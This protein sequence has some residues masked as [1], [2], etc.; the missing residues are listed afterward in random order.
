MANYAV[1]FASASSQYASFAALA[2]ANPGGSNI[3]WSL[4][5]KCKGASSEDLYLLSD[6]TEY[7]IL[8][9]SGDVTYNRGG[10]VTTWVGAVTT[11]S[12]Y[13]TIRIEVTWTGGTKQAELFVNTVSKGF[14]TVGSASVGAFTQIAKHS[15]NYHNQEIDY[16]AYTDN[17]SAANNRNYLFDDGSGSTVTDSSGNGNNATLVNSPTWV[18]LS[19]GA[20]YTLTP[21]TGSLTLTGG[22]IGLLFDRVLSVGA[23]SLAASGGSIN[24]L[25]DRAIAPETGSLSLTGGAVGIYLNRVLNPETG[26]LTLTG[27]DVVLTYTPGGFTYTL[28]PETG[29]LSVIGGAVPVLHNKILAPATGSLTLTG[30]DNGL[31]YNREIVPAAGSLAATGAAVGLYFDRV[32][33]LDTGSLT[34]TG[35]SITLTYSAQ[36]IVIRHLR[37]Y[38]DSK[39]TH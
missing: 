28:T 35:S 23:G 14:K 7:L 11:P 12:D 34:L 6:N 38:T 15:A 18:L 25:Y 24:L 2:S 20:T 9:S 22:A 16:F 17:N 39:Y 27:S 3:S 29:A 33:G 31:F 8:R 32:I 10:I 4:E 36:N 19:G 13:N 5:I 37:A 1:S 26:S 21:E 30:G